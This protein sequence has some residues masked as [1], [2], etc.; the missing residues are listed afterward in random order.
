MNKLVFFL[1][2]SISAQLAPNVPVIEVGLSADSIAKAASENLQRSVA[3]AEAKI[4]SAYRSAS[5]L[6]PLSPTLYVDG[7]AGKQDT[8]AALSALQDLESKRASQFDKLVA[9]SIAEFSQLKK[10]FLESPLAKTLN[11]R[12]MQDASSI[13]GLAR[14]LESQRDAAEAYLRSKILNYELALAH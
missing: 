4:D 9:A 6:A 11:V 7:Q 13:G 10:S 2:A 5:F 1:L 12:V 3:A 8:S 14:N